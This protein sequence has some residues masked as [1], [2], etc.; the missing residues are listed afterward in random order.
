MALTDSSHP[1]HLQSAQADKASESHLISA[2]I[3][4]DATEDDSDEDDDVQESQVEESQVEESQIAQD[5]QDDYHELEPSSLNPRSFTLEPTQQDSFAHHEV[6]G[7]ATFRTSAEARGAWPKA[8]DQACQT[9]PS[10]M[11]AGDENVSQDLVNMMKVCLPSTESM[12]T[13][14]I[15]YTPDSLQQNSGHS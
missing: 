3:D 5:E 12:M 8:F 9:E 7:V 10:S 4:D 1:Y 13:C 2:Q 11:E 14:L 15:N 6:S